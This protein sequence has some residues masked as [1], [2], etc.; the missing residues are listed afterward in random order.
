MEEL[1]SRCPRWA[2]PARGRPALCAVS[3]GLDSMCLLDLLDRWC[4]ERQG[5]IVAAHFNHRLRGAEADRDEAFVRDWCAGR[6]IPFV[7]GSGDVRG[8]AEREGLSLEEA[9]RTLRYAFLRR[10]AEK[11]GQHIRIYTAHHADDNAETI[12][13]NLIRGTGVA[14]LA[15]MAYHQNGI[16]QAP[17]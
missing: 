8:L 15:G 7:S 17:A 16:F 12:L 11:L 2:L 1:L 14:G 13:F 3:G 5:R 4:R 6:D 10:E 9:A